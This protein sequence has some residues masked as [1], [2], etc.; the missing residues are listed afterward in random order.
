MSVTI[1]FASIAIYLGLKR[2]NAHLKMKGVSGCF[3]P[4]ALSA[5]ILCT[6]FSWAADL[7]E[8]FGV[9]IVGPIPPGLPPPKFPRLDKLTSLAMVRDF[10]GVALVAAIVAF[11]VTHSI[12]KSLAGSTEIKA[13]PQLF[14]F[15]AA[16]LMGSMFSALPGS[17]SLSRAAIIDALGARTIVHN[18]Y[19]FCLMTAVLLFLSPLLEVNMYAV[20]LPGVEVLRFG[21]SITFANKDVLRRAVVKMVEKSDTEVRHADKEGRPRKPPLQV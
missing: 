8:S 16:N 19:T 21:A 14:A 17:A 15:G 11:I 6:L 7:Q 9:D 20:R 10:A 12:A 2:Y 13:T 4:E 1:G 18:V 5:V 3:L